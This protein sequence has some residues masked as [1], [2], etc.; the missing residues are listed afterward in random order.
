MEGLTAIS[1]P[2]LTGRSEPGLAQRARLVPGWQDD[3]LCHGGNTLDIIGQPHRRTHR[4]P[5]RLTAELADSP[6]WT[7]DS[8]HLLYQSVDR[9]KMSR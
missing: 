7:G 8:R 1:P 6:S 9:L 4:P 3:G 2:F 5:Y